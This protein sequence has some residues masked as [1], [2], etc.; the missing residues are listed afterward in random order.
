MLEVNVNKACGTLLLTQALNRLGLH[1][2]AYSE[3]YNRESSRGADDVE[4]TKAGLMS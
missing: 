2:L 3:N 4:Y 1:A